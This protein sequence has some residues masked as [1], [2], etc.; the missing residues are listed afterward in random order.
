MSWNGTVRCSWCHKKGHNRRGCPDLHKYAEQNP[1]GWAA[2][3]LKRSKESAQN[4]L[5]GYCDRP[6]HNRRTC[7]EL[8]ADKKE[9]RDLCVR[10]RSEA[11][12]WI[13]RN[14]AGVGALVAFARHD[15]P[16]EKVGLVRKGHWSWLNPARC[17]HRLPEGSNPKELHPFLGQCHILGVGPAAK[18]NE[19]VL[20]S[21]LKV[22]S[23]VAF[24][25]GL[26]NL[27]EGWK[28]GCDEMTL[29]AQEDHF[30][31]QSRNSIRRYTLRRP[32]EIV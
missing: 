28:K 27:P 25:E 2:Q 31:E 22:L 13:K 23:P 9:Y 8:K 14:G 21:N 19:L 6:G 20:I 1:D 3:Q 17:D 15:G 4:R 16:C 10:M 12:A 18:P 26:L 11:L 32:E 24:D 7:P 29:R 5:C 30:K